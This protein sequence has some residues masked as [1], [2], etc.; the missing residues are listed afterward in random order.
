MTEVTIVGLDLENRVFQA[1][2]AMA[3]G[4]VTIR[5]KLSQG[6]VFVF[7]PDMP[8]CVVA[9]ES[10]ATAHYSARLPDALKV[11]GIQ[12]PNLVKILA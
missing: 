2:R 6:Q 11:Y 4:G 8:P 7:F 3:D 5:K 12:C 9:M 1:H 10:Y